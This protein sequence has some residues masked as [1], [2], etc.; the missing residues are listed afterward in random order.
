M[1]ITIIEPLRDALCLTND[2]YYLLTLV[3]NLSSQKR[4]NYQ[5]VMSKEN[6][7]KRVGVS[8]SK[9][10][11]ML[12]TLE[13]KMYIYRSGEGLKPTEFTES[14]FSK[15]GEVMLAYKNGQHSLV[16]G[17]LSKYLNSQGKDY[18][19]GS[20]D[21]DCQND[22]LSNCE[23]NTVNMTV[24]DCQNDIQY[25]KIYKDN[26][27]LT[28]VNSDL[29]KSQKAKDQKKVNS[30]KEEKLNSTLSE[31]S[32]TKKEKSSA[33]KEKK[34]GRED[35]NKLDLWLKKVFR[36]EVWTQNSTWTRRWLS[37]LYSLS[38]KIG[39]EEFARR[40][41]LLC[42]DDFKFKNCGSLKFIHEQ[43]RSMPVSKTAQKKETLYIGELTPEEDFVFERFYT[44]VGNPTREEIDALLEKHRHEI[45]V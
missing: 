8:E 1:Y 10:Y 2:Q 40:A 13:E 31:L 42:K 32:E 25:I 41:K 3:Y 35:L 45:I 28:K 22:I 9:V 37:N 38:Q 43:I 11:R 44:G 26:N 30:D 15:D 29:E 5:C 18:I 36:R 23:S 24:Q 14:I 12:K 21:T 16:T 33:K 39:S 17:K 4:Y 20:K 27:I 34:Y 6:L 19:N 7:A